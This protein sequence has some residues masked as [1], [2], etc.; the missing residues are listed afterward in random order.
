MLSAFIALPADTVTVLPVR[1]EKR[2]RD[3]KIYK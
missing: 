2:K 3:L 1:V